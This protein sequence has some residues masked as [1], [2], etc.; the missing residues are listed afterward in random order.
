MEKYIKDW[1]LISLSFNFPTQLLEDSDDVSVSIAVYNRYLTPKDN[2][3]S[4]G[5]GILT[6]ALVMETDDEAKNNILRIELS[7]SVH[8]ENGNVP[9]LQYVKKHI[10]N[11]AYDILRKKL[12]TLSDEFNIPKF[13][14]PPPPSP[15]SI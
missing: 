15:S 9:D 13:E 12:D 4:Q 7:F 6:I 8:D 2:S 5:C 10:Y 14:L 11:I 1:Q 3:K